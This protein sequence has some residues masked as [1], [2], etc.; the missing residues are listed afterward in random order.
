MHTLVLLS[1]QPALWLPETAEPVLRQ[2]S[3]EE[4]IANGDRG[5]LISHFH[6]DMQT[7]LEIH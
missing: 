2:Y 7:E 4:E 6:N 5:F 3:Y 1:P